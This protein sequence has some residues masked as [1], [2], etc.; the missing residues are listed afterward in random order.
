MTEAIYLYC[1][2]RSGRLA[3]IQGN[4]IN[5]PNPL[6][7]CTFPG[8]T[9][10][11][12]K[13]ATEEF[14]GPSAERSMQDL[15]WV[16]PRACRH[17]EVIE[18]MMSH[19]PVVP[20]RFGTLFSSLES[21]GNFLK[22]N[23]TAILQFLDRVADQEEWAI[24]GLL[25]RMRA[26]ETIRSVVVRTRQEELSASPGK[27]YIQEQRM[28]AAAEKELNTRLK[29]VCQSVA[30][31]LNQYA[32]D[33]CELPVR[34]RTVPAGDREIILN[35]AFLVP[36]NARPYFCGRVDEVNAGYSQWGLEFEVTGPW[37][38]YSFSPCL[39]ICQS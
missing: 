33:F 25:D 8:I 35:W 10:V 20:A 18:R 3:S 16:G 32:S 37:P 15:A 24:K 1:L 28:M 19:S 38:P 22:A 26:S 31:K 17:A 36:Q 27:R 5:G 29:Q 7:L 9:A 21:L 4:D 34:D 2:A 6:F 30:K 12:S 39:A 11:V 23:E 14:C 13:V